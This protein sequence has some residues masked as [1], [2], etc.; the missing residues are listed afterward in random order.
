MFYGNDGNLSQEGSGIIN[1]KAQLSGP[2]AA[3]GCFSEWER[4]GQ[5]LRSWGPLP[6]L[7]AVQVTHSH[8]QSSPVSTIS[9]CS[10]KLRSDPGEPQTAVFASEPP[11]AVVE[12]G[13]PCGPLLVTFLSLVASRTTKLG[14]SPAHTEASVTPLASPLQVSRLWGSSGTQETQGPAGQGT[15]TAPGCFRDSSFPLTSSLVAE[16]PWALDGLG[17]PQRK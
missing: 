7:P 10:L 17:R 11:E 1:S 8:H 13:V 12:I 2:W 15:V 14:R 9:R 3:A 16:E 6:W 5:L 4:K